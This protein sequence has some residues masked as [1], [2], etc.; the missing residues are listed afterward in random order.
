MRTRRTNP[1]LH[2]GGLDTAWHHV[3]RPR[4]RATHMCKERA[5][6]GERP[7]HLVAAVPVLA[8]FHMPV[9]LPCGRGLDRGR[10]LTVVNTSRVCGCVRRLGPPAGP[11]GSGA[12]TWDDALV[13]RRGAG[14]VGIAPEE[15]VN[16]RGQR[17]LCSASQA[18]ATTH[19]HVSK[20]TLSYVGGLQRQKWSR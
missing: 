6:G 15:P 1:G 4:C 3:L 12:C 19:M 9:A 7:Q 5:P 16:H 11:N 8:A 18:T 10:S 2:G 14:D 17:A 13:W 20:A